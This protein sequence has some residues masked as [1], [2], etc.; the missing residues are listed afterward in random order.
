MSP[1]SFDAY[2]SRFQV[3]IRVSALTVRQS[4]HLSPPACLR[5][6]YDCITQTI[7]MCKNV[8]H[9]HRTLRTDGHIASDWVLA[10]LTGL[11]LDFLFKEGQGKCLHFAV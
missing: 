6:Y 2:R 4:F 11:L 3:P 9:L 10:D 5:K 1:G 8:Q 7:F